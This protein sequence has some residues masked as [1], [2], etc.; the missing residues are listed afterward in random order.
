MMVCVGAVGL[1]ET[2]G[3]DAVD[4]V[5]ATGEGDGEGD[6][7]IVGAGAATGAADANSGNTADAGCHCCH[8]AAAT[9]T[10]GINS[11]LLISSNSFVCGIGPVGVEPER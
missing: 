8:P 10:E 9:C 3:M 7:A 2:A 4:A 1:G 5:A 11:P 6:I